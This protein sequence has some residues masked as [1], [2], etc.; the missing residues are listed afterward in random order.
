MG[1]CGRFS[2]DHART[3]NLNLYYFATKHKCRERLRC[4]AELMG[5]DDKIWDF[6]PFGPS[7]IYHRY[8]HLSNPNIHNNKLLA[9]ET[10]MLTLLYYTFS[11]I[12]LLILSMFAIEII[13]KSEDE[14]HSDRQKHDLTDHNR[15]GGL[16]SSFLGDD[17]NN[18]PQI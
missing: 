9:Q 6:G 2:E 3:K 14:N 16:T 1:R 13:G 18:A 17:E 12:F 4:Y 11:F 8:R 5:L 7:L 10:T 15:L